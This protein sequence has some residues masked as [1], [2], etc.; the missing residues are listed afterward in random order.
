M[1][2][3]SLCRF[4]WSRPGSGE[5]PP[6]SAAGTVAGHREKKAQVGRWQVVVLADVGGGWDGEQVLNG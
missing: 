5:Q 2:L 1:L 3:F 4:S 6:S